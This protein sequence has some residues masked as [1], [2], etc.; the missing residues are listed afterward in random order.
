MN[1]LNLQINAKIRLYLEDTLA[2]PLTMLST[3]LVE[4]ALPPHLFLH[5]TVPEFTHGPTIKI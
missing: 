3:P 4:D 1:E 2:P 5:Q